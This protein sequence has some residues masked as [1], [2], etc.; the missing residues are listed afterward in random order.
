MH[1][2]TSISMR[3]ASSA[4]DWHARTHTSGVA[5]PQGANIVSEQTANTSEQTATVDTQ[6]APAAPVPVNVTLSV[7]PTSVPVDPSIPNDLHELASVFI[8]AGKLIARRVDSAERTAA[9]TAGALVKSIDD[10]TADPTVMALVAAGLVNVEQARQQSAHAG[11]AARDAEWARIS[12]AMAPL[13]RRMFRPSNAPVLATGASNGVSGD[14]DGARGFPRS[15]DGVT[16]QVVNRPASTFNANGATA[17]GQIACDICVSA[18]GKT[19]K[20]IRAN[21]S[22]AIASLTSEQI[23]SKRPCLVAAAARMI[24]DHQAVQ[25]TTWERLA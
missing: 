10:G 9:E 4:F 14:A 19:A 7:K 24:S 22:K 17:C 15:R 8:Y 25:A 2:A 23:E 6:T 1:K 13:A 16:Y 11:K 20:G 18:N 12:E 5:T 3:D 21:I